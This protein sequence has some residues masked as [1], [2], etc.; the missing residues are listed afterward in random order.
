VWLAAGGCSPDAWQALA[1]TALELKLETRRPA[2]RR[3]VPLA[4]RFRA[5]SLGLLQEQLG[6]DE[7]AENELIEVELGIRRA[8]ERSLFLGYYTAHG[9]DLAF[10]RFGTVALLERLGY[11]DV[12]VVVDDVAEGDRMRMLGT[13]G[14][15]EHVLVE[16][17]ELR[18]RV[19]G[20]DVLHVHGLALRRPAA[21]FSGQ[22]PK[23]PGQDAPGLGLPREAGEFLDAT[24]RRLG[25]AG[26]AFHPA[27]FHT[28][29]AARSRFRFEDDARQGRFVALCR[30]LQHLPLVEATHAVADG[31]V[32]LDGAPYAREADVMVHWLDRPA[33]AASPVVQ[34]AAELTRFAVQ[35]TR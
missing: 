15:Q 24:A 33:E 11:S 30:D 32:R 27:W 31:R 12:R 14:G 2:S 16:V 18:K 4:A 9:I 25:L 21:A 17:V 28:A 23:L 7:Q 8:P 13:H 29:W 1:G 35:Q 22:R 3:Y 26:V 19:A 6:P 10:S 20:E 34:K 5:L